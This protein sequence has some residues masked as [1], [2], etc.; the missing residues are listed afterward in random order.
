VSQCI[1]S[2]FEPNTKYIFGLRSRAAAASM[3][4]QYCTLAVYSGSSCEPN[5]LFDFS[6]TGITGSDGTNWVVGMSRGLSVPS[7]GSFE[8]QCDGE[9]GAGYFDQLFLSPATQATY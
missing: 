1:N 7:G 6:S 3:P 2:G 4:N 9:G 5:S 8:V